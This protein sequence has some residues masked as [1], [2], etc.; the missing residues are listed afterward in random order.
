MVELE[1]VCRIPV[2]FSEIDSMGI[3]W[4][5][6]YVV[7]LEDGRESFGRH[8]PGIGYDI[9]QQTGIYAPIYDVHTR[10]YASLKM[11]DVAVIHTTFVEKRGARLDFSYR[12]YRESDNEL[13]CEGETTQLFTGPDGS[14]MLDLPD[15][16]K[17]WKRKFFSPRQPLP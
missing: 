5:G 16:V 11:G 2:K 13:C 14:L 8:F 15:F 17:E 10:H 1:D 9:M 6:N 3:V 7:Y 12:I 4:H